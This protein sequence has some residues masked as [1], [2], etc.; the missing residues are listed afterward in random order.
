MNAFPGNPLQRIR[1]DRENC[2]G[3]RLRLWFCGS[4]RRR[5]TSFSCNEG[6]PFALPK[7]APVVGAAT[8]V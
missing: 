3:Q 5:T 2:F 7:F 6:A 8:I 4:C 1:M